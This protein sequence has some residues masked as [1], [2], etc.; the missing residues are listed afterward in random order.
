MGKNS[1]EDVEQEAEWASEL[2]NLST[3]DLEKLEPIFK[4][5]TGANGEQLGLSEGKFQ[6]ALCTIHGSKCTIFEI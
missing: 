1:V 3:A 4:K 5:A 6:E 2:H